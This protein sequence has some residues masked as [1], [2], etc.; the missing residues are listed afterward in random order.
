M[1]PHRIGKP[2]GRGCP[3]LT[4]WEELV[5]LCFYRLPRLF[6]SVS[7]LDSWI[8]CLDGNH[9]PWSLSGPW[10]DL[11]TV[12]HARATSALDCCTFSSY[13]CL[14][15]FFGWCQQDG[16]I[17]G[18]QTKIAHWTKAMQAGSATSPPLWFTASSDLTLTYLD[19]PQLKGGLI[20]PVRHAKW[21]ILIFCDCQK[22]WTF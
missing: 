5:T 1:D 9:L 13:R 4:E 19:L 16:V 17:S 2:A 7:S 14:E 11:P 8:N 12:I 20:V 21:F 18:T 22:S 6:G 3:G 15:A 10:A